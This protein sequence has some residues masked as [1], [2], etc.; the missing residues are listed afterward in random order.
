MEEFLVQLLEQKTVYLFEI[1]IKGN[2]GQ[3]LDLWVPHLEGTFDLILSS[4]ILFG[5][6]VQEIVFNQIFVFH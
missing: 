1:V 2:T 6:N 3:F 4:F 5:H